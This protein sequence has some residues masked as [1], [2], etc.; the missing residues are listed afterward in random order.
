MESGA[1][2]KRPVF[3]RG[4]RWAA[5]AIALM[6][7]GASTAHAAFEP[8]EVDPRARAMGGA[9]TAVEGGWAGLYHNP[10]AGAMN[11]D[12]SFGVS[13]VQPYRTD[14][15]KLSAAGVAG[16]LPGK[17]G[18][19]NF[20]FR[21]LATE[22][23]DQ[24]LDAQNTFSF[25]HGFRLHQDVS[26]TIAF[27]WNLNLFNQEFGTSVSG[28]EPGS[29]TAV[30]LDL[31]ARITIRNR[32]SVGFLAQNINNPT[33]GDLDVEELPRRVTGGIA[34]Y[35]YAGVLTTFDLDSV[36]GEKPRFRG[37]AEFELVDW[38]ALRVGVATDP[39]IFTGGVGLDWRGIGFHYGFSSGPGPL[40][41][42][43]QVGL[44]LSPSFLNGQEGD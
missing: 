7:A 23:Q 14:Y 31:A 3:R 22:F 35:P 1:D 13:Y 32:T 33:I 26:S 6:A 42:S 28:A 39:G 34:Y 10:A 4:R 44:S 9:F 8:L 2:M 21:R 25:G 5:M 40:D 17:L 18:G 11:E 19:F 24:S 36:L 20:G 41:E 15:L 43:H 38:A 27:G 12:L 29:A 16:K 30:G 37:G